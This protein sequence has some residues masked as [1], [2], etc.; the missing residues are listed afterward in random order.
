MRDSLVEFTCRG[1]NPSPDTVFRD[2]SSNNRVAARH[3]V[4]RY[5]EFHECPFLMQMQPILGDNAI[6]IC[7][8]I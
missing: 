3:P 5:R 7:W 6:A 1:I 8:D 4:F 2:N